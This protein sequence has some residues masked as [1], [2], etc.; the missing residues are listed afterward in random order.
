MSPL[1]IRCVPHQSV[2]HRSVTE[3]NQELYV[4]QPTAQTPIAQTSG[5]TESFDFAL[6][7]KR[8]QGLPLTNCIPVLGPLPLFK[9][10][11]RDPVAGE[12]KHR[13]FR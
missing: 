4:P 7:G 9:K 3:V 2:P 6:K 11:M 10:N 12:G 13:H 5:T 8:C 1:S